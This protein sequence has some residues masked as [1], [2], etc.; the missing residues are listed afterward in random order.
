VPAHRPLEVLAAEW[1]AAERQATTMGNS[2]RFEGDARDIS[3]EYDDAI[4]ATSLED[5]LLAVE[6]ARGIQRNQEMGSVAWVEA[7][8]VSELLRTEYEAARAAG[9]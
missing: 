2:G 6:A 9:R 7:R 1:L 4:R 5:L 3:A 8:R